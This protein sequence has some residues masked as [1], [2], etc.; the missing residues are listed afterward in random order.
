MASR[1]QQPHQTVRVGRLHAAELVCDVDGLPVTV[2]GEAAAVQVSCVPERFSDGR[3]V[4][5]PRELVTCIRA[6][7]C[8]EVAEAGPPAEPVAEYPA[9]SPPD[10]DVLESQ[11]GPGPQCR[12]M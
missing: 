8:R 1:L 5:F 6:G 3:L 10:A 2:L 4:R 9:A 7:M 11:S 12:T